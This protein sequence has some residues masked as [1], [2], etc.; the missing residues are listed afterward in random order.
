MKRMLAAVLT[1]TLFFAAA[2][3]AAASYRDGVY[4]GFYYSD[5]VEQVAVQFEL[6]DGR[7]RSIVLRRLTNR[8]G[9]LLDEDASETQK[10]WLSHF[11]VLCDHLLGKEVS[12]IDELYEPEKIL[13]AAGITASPHVPYSRLISALW[14]GLNRRP[15]KLVDTSKL[16]EAAP[17]ADGTYTGVYSEDGGEQVVLEFSVLDS[18]ISNIRYVKLC[19]K[20]VD[21]LSADAPE[22]I[23]RI[24][25]QF[26]ALIAYLEGRPIA[27]VNDLYLPGNIVP[28]TD[29]FSAATLRSPK[30]ISAIWDGL[31]KNAYEIR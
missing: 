4:R 13:A 17:Y 22:A 26:E 19:Y 21:Y 2:S 11:N 20:D 29:A 16:P 8:W 23:R 27:A 31:N 25:G 7:F 1:L 5:G 30:V 15:F 3:G 18:V 24:T 9:N 6:K 12:A 14:D 28:D 10:Q